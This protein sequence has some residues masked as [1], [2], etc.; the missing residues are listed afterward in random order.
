MARKKRA[1]ADPSR[2][3]TTSIASIGSAAKLAVEPPPEPASSAPTALGV[4]PAVE[5]SGRY[6]GGD[7][8]GAE[9]EPEAERTAAPLDAESRGRLEQKLL[10]M[11]QGKPSLKKLQ[12]TLQ[13]LQQPGANCAWFNTRAEAF[14]AG[15]LRLCVGCGDGSYEMSMVLGGRWSPHG[16][17]V[18]FFESEGKL[19]QRYN[20]FAAN[21]LLL[22][23]L[24][25]QLHFEVDCTDLQAAAGGAL[26]GLAA[27][28]GQALRQVLFV[29]PQCGTGFPGSERWH[30][31][32]TV[33]LSGF[34][35]SAAAAAAAL[36]TG[37]APSTGT[38]GNANV[39]EVALVLMD[40]A[41]YSELPLV[42]LAKTAGLVAL[43]TEP[44]EG[45]C[46]GL[47]K[48]RMTNYDKVVKCDEASTRH[49]F[50]ARERGQV[51]AVSR[52]SSN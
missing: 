27:A 13:Q 51:A 31:E 24:G 39:T 14:G 8:S 6:S 32:H 30:A 11:L 5:D 2:Y 48:H 25:A 43:R 19:R 50:A 1:K 3:A 16:L 42:E 37:R 41:P 33:L 46:H 40:R 20:N 47:Y 23:A 29:F 38:G 7:G 36:A 49:V 21:A 28:A 4:E 45:G 15:A 10:G 9:P 22:R 44:F 35:A 26:L 12:H 52:P 34:F 18:T 17:L